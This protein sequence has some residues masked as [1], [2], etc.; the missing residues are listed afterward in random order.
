MANIVLVI[1]FALVVITILAV[2]AALLVLAVGL[3]LDA[4]AKFTDPACKTTVDY[5]ATLKKALLY[6]INAAEA[7]AIWSAYRCEKNKDVPPCWEGAKSIHTF[8]TIE[9]AVKV[10]AVHL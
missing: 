4:E 9:V 5:T 1:L 10:P 7:D 2:L 8:A 3:I 6:A